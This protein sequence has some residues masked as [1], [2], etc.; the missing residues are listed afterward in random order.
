M[1]HGVHCLPNRVTSRHHAA[2]CRY[3]LHHSSDLMRAGC[4]LRFIEREQL[5][6]HVIG[7]NGSRLFERSKSCSR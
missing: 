2:T 4:Y 7:I 6:T 1:V 3:S 5:V